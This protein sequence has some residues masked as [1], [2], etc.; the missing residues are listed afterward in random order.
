MS[1]IVHKTFLKLSL[2]FSKRVKGTQYNKHL[3][4]VVYFDQCLGSAHS[5]RPVEI[6]IFIIFVVKTLKKQEICS[7]FLQ[8]THFFKSFLKNL[9][10]NFAANFLLF[11]LFAVKNIKIVYFDQRLECAAPKCWSKYTTVFYSNT[12]AFLSL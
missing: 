3:L 1:S 8:K 10:A 4:F 2:H 12:T 11:Q 6:V 5:K 7:K 9:A